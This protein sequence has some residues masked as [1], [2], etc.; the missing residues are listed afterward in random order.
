MEAYGERGSVYKT[1]RISYMNNYFI[2]ALLIVVLTMVLPVYNVQVTFTPTTFWE[3]IGTALTTVALFAFVFMLFEP[4][5]E[6]TMRKYIVTNHELLLI[7][8]ILRKHRVA[9]PYNGVSDVQVNKG[10]IGRMLDFGNVEIQGFKTTVVMKGVREPETVYN[11]I[12]NKIAHK[13]GVKGK[14]REM[15]MD[16][17]EYPDKV[18]FID[19]E[20]TKKG[21][22]KSKKSKKSEPKAEKKIKAAQGAEES[23]KKTNRTI[24]KGFPFLNR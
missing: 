7:E 24:F 11:I 8:G 16:E 22:K 17:E 20:P 18:E 23:N 4:E 12:K 2:A 15:Q 3:I 9:I 1:S 21:K 6:K 14:R 10:I 19:L 5:I 13:T